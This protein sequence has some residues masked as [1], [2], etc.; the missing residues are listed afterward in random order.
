[1]KIRMTTFGKWI[2]MILTDLRR[3]E[4]TK[5]VD[6]PQLV[7]DFSV[8]GENIAVWTKPTVSVDSKLG[9]FVVAALGFEP[10][11]GYEVE[12]DSLI[13]VTVLGLVSKRKTKKGEWVDS[14]F[15]FKPF[16]KTP[17]SPSPAIRKAQ[18]KRP[19]GDAKLEDYF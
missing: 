8:N 14:I 12:R 1:M 16:D 17:P 18:Q 9:D 13:N 19:T 4:K 5:Y 2:P 7:W 15:R 10:P 3:I 6:E 11:N